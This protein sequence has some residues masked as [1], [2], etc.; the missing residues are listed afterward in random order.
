M[1]MYKTR[2]KVFCVYY[3]RVNFLGDPVDLKYAVPGTYIITQS[4]TVPFQSYVLFNPDAT[5]PAPALSMLNQ[6]CTSDG[7]H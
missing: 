2:A 7:T 5:E 3:Y 6:L 1:K 4:K